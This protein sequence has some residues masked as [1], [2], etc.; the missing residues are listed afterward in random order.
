MQLFLSGVFFNIKKDFTI[1]KK[2]DG[3][4]Y[5]KANVYQTPLSLYGTQSINPLLNSII[6][7][8]HEKEEEFQPI[9]RSPDCFSS[10]ESLLS[11]Y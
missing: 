11:Y 4:L 2:K 10:V 1:E 6:S 3:T 9:T 8:N 5:Y 7:A